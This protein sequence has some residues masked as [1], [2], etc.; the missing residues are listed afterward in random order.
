ML[1]ASGL[2]DVLLPGPQESLVPAARR[3]LPGRPRG[4]PGN[5]ETNAVSLS[6]ADNEVQAHLGLERGVH[7]V[8]RHIPGL[9][10][11]H[12]VHDDVA[13]LWNASTQAL[14]RG[15]KSPSIPGGGV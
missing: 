10:T 7:C 1:S 11:D 14:V 5:A 8:E 15:P 9:V 12:P 13:H 2:R 6:L 4:R 3:R